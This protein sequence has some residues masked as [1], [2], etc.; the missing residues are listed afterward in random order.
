MCSFAEKIDPSFSDDICD[1][2]LAVLNTNRFCIRSVFFFCLAWFV[3][4]PNSGWLRTFQAG[5]RLALMTPEEAEI[6]LKKAGDCADGECTVDEVSDLIAVLKGQQKEI[7][8]RL[9]DVKKTIYDL[10]HVNVKADRQTDEVKETVR[11][12]FRIFSLGD[13]S[14]GNNYP[15]LSKPTG[16]SGEVGDG[17]QTAYDALPPKKYVKK[18]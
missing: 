16:W 3:V 13:K 9:V 12:L 8:E 17:P 6:V 18:E 14:S 7:Y 11:A 1:T 5:T 4:F 15:S 10:E 2:S